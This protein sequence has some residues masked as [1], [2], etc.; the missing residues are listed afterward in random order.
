VGRRLWRRRL[1]ELQRCALH[2]Q[3]SLCALMLIAQLIEQ[4]RQCP[5]AQ[6]SNR[7]VRRDWAVETCRRGARRSPLHA[8]GLPLRIPGSA[9]PF[10]RPLARECEQE[11]SK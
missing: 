6:G 5:P 2:D 8:S 1:H 10:E 7:V 9:Y 3:R 11:K 4:G